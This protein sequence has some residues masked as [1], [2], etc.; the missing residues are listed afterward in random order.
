M[1]LDTLTRA[2]AEQ[3][4]EHLKNSLAHSQT[5]FKDRLHHGTDLFRSFPVPTSPI[6]AN[7]A[8]VEVGE[9]WVRAERLKQCC[10]R[11]RVWRRQTS[12]PLLQYKQQHL[13]GTS[14]SKSSVGKT[15]DYRMHISLLMALILD[16]YDQKLATEIATGGFGQQQQYGGIIESFP[17]CVAKVIMARTSSRRVAIEQLQSTV[18]ILLQPSSHAR[19]RVFSALCGMDDKFHPPE[20]TKVFLH[21]VERLYHHKAAST[22]MNAKATDGTSIV[23]VVFHNI[24]VTQPVV[25]KVISELFEKDFFWNFGFWKMHFRE[26]KVDYHWPATAQAELE[27]KALGLA[28]VS[29]NTVFNATRK[30]DGDAFL[31]LVLDAWTE[32]AKTLADQLESATDTE[33]KQSNAK[34]KHKQAMQDARGQ[35]A[36][37]SPAEVAFFDELVDEY[38]NAP[39]PWTSTT[40]HRRV[41]AL[42][43]NRPVTELA[44]LYRKHV[45][46]L[47]D[48]RR[49]WEWSH[50]PWEVEWE[51]RVL[52]VR[53]STSE[54][55]GKTS[56]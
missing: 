19:V 54:T 17:E 1:T 3:K 24:G 23:D 6:N 5:E 4:H 11:V 12:N 29:R 47:E 43:A 51:W 16:I 36:P 50:W 56:T 27:E 20:K 48:S 37:L 33:E 45:L 15:S 8:T 9:D 21:I 41:L 30:I 22:A 52:T 35:I 25:L 28:V 42:D 53:E 10:K 13:V 49:V 55:N 7:A 31:E 39:V 18:S 32:R 46:S 40:V 38:W 26:L 2:N 14:T 44:A 34:V